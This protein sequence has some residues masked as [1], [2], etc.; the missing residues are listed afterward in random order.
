MILKDRNRNQLQ[1]Q[2][3]AY[4][5][6]DGQTHYLPE[7]GEDF[8]VGEEVDPCFWQKGTILFLVHLVHLHCGLGRRAAFLRRA[9]S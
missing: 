1:T 7:E 4:A 6:Y 5:R 9:R 2:E 8:V 3:R